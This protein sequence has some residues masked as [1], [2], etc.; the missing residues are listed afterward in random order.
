METGRKS[1]IALLAVGALLIV[2]AAS[3]LFLLDQEPQ[4]FGI[5]LSQNNQVVIA[6]EDVVWYNKSSHEMILTEE[7]KNKLEALTVDVYG[8]PFTV[9]LNGKEIYSGSF[10]TPIS[11]V[12]RSGIVI[13]IFR[14]Q[15][16][17]L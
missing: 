10:W 15:K 2:I 6:D 3:I 14:D 17:E 8:T 4:G 16:S 12:S 1:M 5:Y 13:E 11:S 7:G 9:K